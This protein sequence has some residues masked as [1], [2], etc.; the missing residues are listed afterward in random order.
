MNSQTQAPFY[1]KLSFNLITLALL[2]LAIYYGKEI[3]VPVLFSILLAN[4]LL[5][6][7]RFLEKKRF[8][9]PIA[10]LLPL[11]LSLIIG[12]AIIYFL[13]SQI[14]N[15]V[16][17]LPALQKRLSEVGNTIQH[18]FKA[19]THITIQKQ[20]QYLNEKVS[21]LKDIAP[22]VVGSTIISITGILSY[23][24]LLPI[25][26]FLILY[27]RSL[28]RGFL[29]STFKNG[30]SE[31]VNAILVESAS[32]GQKYLSGLLIETVLVFALNTIGF[33]ILGIKYVFFLALL[34]ALLNLIPYVGMLIANVICMVV[35][36]VSS[37]NTS[38]VFWVFIILALVQF[39]DNNFGM[40]LIVGNHVRINS[41]VT[42]IGVFV[43]GALAGV[44][45]M[46]L[47]IPGLAVLKVIFD[48]VPEL[49]AW[50]MLLGEGSGKKATLPEKFQPDD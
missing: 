30:S 25:Y 29:V 26:T 48:K 1:Q 31:N 19:N 14:M 5:P 46:F 43:G 12:I 32:M 37:S 20:N 39:W 9:K 6:V 42:I 41:L 4:M 38:D 18:W 13:S 21:D 35:T 10:I 50:G 28:I 3:I 7:T 44:S 45:G 22:E 8:P 27:Y 17:D 49:Q 11:L 23:L 47:A 36:L 40:T 24:V 33:F 15:F 2:S 16:D 34:A